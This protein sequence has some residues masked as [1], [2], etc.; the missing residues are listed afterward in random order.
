[1]IGYFYV[2][3]PSLETCN[4]DWWGIKNGWAKLK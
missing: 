3:M 4:P 2:V 1:M